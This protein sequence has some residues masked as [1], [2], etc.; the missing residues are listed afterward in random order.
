MYYDQVPD[1]ADIIVFPI[2]LFSIISDDTSI[3]Y[4]EYCLSMIILS[5]VPSLVVYIYTHIRTCTTYYSAAME[6][7]GQAK[8]EAQSRA[9]A[10]KIEGEALSKPN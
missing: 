6:S 3:V 9:E 4:H 10:A 7:T 8:T 1:N 2:L 5:I